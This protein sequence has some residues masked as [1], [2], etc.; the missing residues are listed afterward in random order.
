MKIHVIG[1][2]QVEI[3]VAVVVGKGH[4]GRV[5]KVNAQPAVAVIINEQSPAAHALHNEFFLRRYFVRKM[6]AGGGGDIRKLRHRSCA[7]IA[8]FAAS[9]GLF[10]GYLSFKNE[11]RK[12]K[13][14]ATLPNRPIHW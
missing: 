9:R 4:R 3:A 10:A 6:N 14:S 5:G 1:D 7:G 2:H 13:R 12:K 8:S 11:E